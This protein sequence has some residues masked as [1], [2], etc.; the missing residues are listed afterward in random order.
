MSSCAT[1]AHRCQAFHAKV[2]EY[3]GASGP[4]RKAAATAFWAAFEDFRSCSYTYCPDFIPPLTGDTPDC[5]ASYYLYRRKLHALLGAGEE[6][7]AEV[8]AEARKFFDHWRQATGKSAIKKD[9]DAAFRTW[10][11]KASEWRAQKETPGGEGALDEIREKY[12]R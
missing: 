3:L 10:I 4:R 1:N 5:L 6:V 11:T 2:D 8:V 9:W 12:G 7:C